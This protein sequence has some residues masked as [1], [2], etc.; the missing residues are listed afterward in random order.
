MTSAP[1]QKVISSVTLP[2]GKDTVVVYDWMQFGQNRAENLE[3]LSH[4][5]A[6]IWRAKLPTSD[7]VDCFVS[8]TWDADCLR[9]NTWGGWAV[10]L[11]PETGEALRMQFVK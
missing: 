2:S 4:D 11:N 9:A 7:G 8:V 6:T 3:R 5:G 10:W 1:K